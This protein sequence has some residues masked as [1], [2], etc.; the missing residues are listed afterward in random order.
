M[1]HVITARMGGAIERVPA[2][3]T[4]FA[5]RA[6]ANLLWIIGLWDDPAADPEPH[7]AWVNDV[8]ESARPYSTGGVYVNALDEEGPDRVRAAY[9]DGDVRAAA[10]GQARLG[11][12]QRVPP[13]PEHPAGRAFAVSGANVNGGWVGVGSKC[14]GAQLVA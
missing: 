2:G 13:Q 3:D 7:R 14:R 5:H 6:A 12:R 10:A 11:P 4:A 8:L 9:G 1:S